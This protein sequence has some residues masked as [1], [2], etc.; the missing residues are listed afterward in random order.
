MNYNGIGFCNSMCFWIANSFTDSDYWTCHTRPF[1]ENGM[2][3]SLNFS[4]LLLF[5]VH[6]ALVHKF[7]L[8]QYPRSSIL[9]IS[10]THGTETLQVEVWD[11]I[12][13]N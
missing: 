4:S 13:F 3:K 10:F 8:C 11:H 6:L 1:I 2:Q 5:T 12:I 7:K 9:L